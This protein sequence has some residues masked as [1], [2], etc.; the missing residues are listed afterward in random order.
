M[1][2]LDLNVTGLFFGIAGL[3]VSSIYIVVSNN[4]LKS[5][6]HKITYYR[7]NSFFVSGVPKASKFSAFSDIFTMCYKASTSFLNH[8]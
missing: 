8:W 5:K 1:Y 7:K 4:N 2:D 3:V 6:K